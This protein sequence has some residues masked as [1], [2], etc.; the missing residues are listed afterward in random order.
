MLTV[1]FSLSAS[2]LITYVG[3][4]CADGVNTLFRRHIYLKDSRWLPTSGMRQRAM[5]RTVIYISTDSYRVSE[6]VTRSQSLCFIEVS[7]DVF[8]VF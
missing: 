5:I 3:Y 7:A 8:S 1:L 6:I 4:N 2:I